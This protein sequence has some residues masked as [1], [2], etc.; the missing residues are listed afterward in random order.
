VTCTISFRPG[1]RFGAAVAA[2]LISG[3]GHIGKLQ[4]GMHTVSPAP[5]RAMFGDTLIGFVP[6]TGD[7]ARRFL[8]NLRD[9]YTADTLNIMVFGDN[10]PGYRISRLDPDFVN[11]RGMFS[12]NPVRIARGLITIPLALVK[13]LVPDLALIR[14]IPSIIRHSPTWG[15]EHQ[16]LKAMTAKIDSLKTSGRIVTAVINTGDLVEDG[17]YPAHWERFL[18]ITEPLT[19]RVPY[20]PVA[21]NHEKTYTVEGVENWRTAT[22]LP[23]GGD[24]L[25]Y[26]FDTADGWVRF[27]AL[28]SNPIVDPGKHW[29]REVQVKYSDEEVTWLVERVKEHRGP[30]VVMMHHPPFSSSVHRMEWQTDAVLVERRERMVRALHDAGISMIA[31]GHEHAYQRALL[32]WPDAVLITLVSGGA[33]APL[34]HIPSPSA[35]AQIFS[36]YKVAGS[37]VK[38]E[39]VTTAQVFNF[40]HLRLW[41]GGG[42]FYTYAV[43]KDASVKL[44]DKVLIDLNRYGIPKIDQRKV[45]IAPSKG[46]SE[47]M[48]TNSAA[49]MPPAAAKVDS[50]SASDRLLSKPPPGNARRTRTPRTNRR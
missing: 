26:C 23:V 16:V 34:H 10:R 8:G 21:G 32:T 4:Y 9:G 25:Y 5:L 39:N 40:T 13:G 37:I 19:S 15:R 22:G 38:P 31:S 1:R 7:S 43:E 33:G 35:S 14:D 18:R 11:I 45:P 6:G 50:T 17:R 46:P 44:I 27:I 12:L 47:S 20:F 29:T 41:F 3:C 36:E 24:R 42:D 28:D 30:V 48:K 49:G 2:L